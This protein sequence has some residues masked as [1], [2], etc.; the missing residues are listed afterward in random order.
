MKTYTQEEIAKI[1][2]DHKKW[3]SE[4]EGTRANLSGADLSRAN[5]SRANLSG[6]D[7]SGADLSRANLSG[8]NLSGAEY[9]DNELRGFLQ[10]GPIGSRKSILQVFAVGPTELI[11]KTGCF[12]G[13]TDEFIFQINDTHSGSD[14]GRNYLSAIEFAKMMLPPKSVE[15]TP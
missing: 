15:V 9:N 4:N 13:N 5:L 8:A 2:A 1:L 6:A 12:S 3:L 14:H 11:F 7:L 10:I